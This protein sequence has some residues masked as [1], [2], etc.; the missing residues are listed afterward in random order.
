MC[1]FLHY[2]TWEWRSSKPQDLSVRTAADKYYYETLD[3]FSIALVSYGKQF[4]KV[5]LATEPNA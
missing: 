1:R 3:V 4:T 5:Q 2:E